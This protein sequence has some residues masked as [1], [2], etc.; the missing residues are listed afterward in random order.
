MVVT[1]VFGGGRFYVQSAGDQKVTSI[2]NQLASLSIKD[3]PILGSFNPKKGDIVLAQFSLDNSWNRAMVNSISLSLFLCFVCFLFTHYSILNCVQI[4]NAPRAAVQSPD[5]KF[6]V[7]YIDYGNQE[8]VPYSAIRQID[9]SVSSAPGLAQLCRLAYMKVP[10]LEEDFG[11]EAVEYLHTITLGS[12]KE[13]KAVI[14]ERDTSGGKVKG[15]G[16]GTEFAVTLTAVDDEISVNAAMLQVG[17]S[18]TFSL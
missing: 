6:E 4:V 18:P 14:E 11:P 7:F 3:A 13:F 16:T 10:S 2:Q 5:E 12:G 17:F 8:T 15:Q 1:E 9:P